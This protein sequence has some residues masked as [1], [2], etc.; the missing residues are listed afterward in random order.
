MR[1]ETWLGE[2]EAQW[3][4]APGRQQSDGGS[5]FVLGERFGN[6]FVGVQPAFGYEGDPMK[7]LFE[8]GFAPTHAF[9]AFYRFLREDFGAHALL[10]FGTHGALEFMPGKQ[11]GLSSACWPDRLVGDVPNFYLYAA[12]N[13]SEGMVA[14]RRGAATLVSHLTPPITEAGLY[15]GL[16]DLKSSIERWRGLPP[17]GASAHEDL[18]ELIQAQAAE[19]D[20]APAEPPWN[21]DAS[22]RIAELGRAVIELEHTLIPCGLHVVGEPPSPAE[23][24]DLL[25]AVAEASGGTPPERPVLEALAAGQSP[26]Q[27]LAAAG[28]RGDRESLARLGELRDLNALLAED[29]E[30]PALLRAL[31]GRFVRPAPG[32][33]LLRT[34]AI[35]PTGRNVHGFDPFRLPS[36]FAM[37]EGVRQA[38]RLVERHRS[39]GHALPESI[40][41]VLWGSDNLKTEGASIAQALAWIGAR[42]RFDSYGRLCGAD[43]VPLD[44]LGHPRIDVVMTLSGIFRDLFPL[45][46]RMLAEASF[47]AA[48]ADEPLERNFVRRNALRHQQEHGCDLETAA[49]RVFSNATGAYGANVSHLVQNDLWGEEDELAEA[50]T[51]R[52][53]FAYGRAGQPVQH[54]ALLQSVLAGAQ[55]AYQNLDSVDVGVTTVDVYFDNLGGISR[56]IQRAAG[57]EVPVYI[58]DPTRGEGRVRTLSEQVALETRTRMLNPR[59][60]EGMLRHGYEGVRQIEEH[61]TNTMGWSATTGQVA[62][63][64]YRQLATTY[65]LDADMRDRMAALNPTAS[66]RVAN[67]LLEANERSYWSPD[68]AMLEALRDAG[69]ELEDRLEGLD[70]G[71]AA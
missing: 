18:A 25:Q 36:A 62:P 68:P 33:D 61:V 38:E 70:P 59:W 41:M 28:S 5:L 17:D 12:N 16:L 3:G 26:E 11:V 4:P 39:D 35:L 22:R 42:P 32:G 30:L 60:V 49:L 48:S 51:Q 45:Q 20:L 9:S 47:L 21:G 71:V 24:T 43:L 53:S 57:S 27:A 37:K 29:H 44:E 15:R 50:W 13:P 40:A 64:V 34:P 23:R 69:A 55:L 2:I 66:A 6:A 7:L 65:V 1:R 10:H 46:T 31:D 63:W 58:G 56:A 19:L 54:G 52:K 14:K 67:R 8:K